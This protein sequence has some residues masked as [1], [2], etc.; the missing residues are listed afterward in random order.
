MTSDLSPSDT[1][2][3][4]KLATILAVI[5]RQAHSIGN[6]V[7]NEYVQATEGVRELEAFAAVVYSSNFEFEALGEDKNSDQGGLKGEEEAG[8]LLR[9]GVLEGESARIVKDS[10]GGKGPWAM[11]EGAWERVSGKER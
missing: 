1:Q 3:K 10:E 5:T 9:E 7:P 11:F 4:A 6:G 8:E 2:S